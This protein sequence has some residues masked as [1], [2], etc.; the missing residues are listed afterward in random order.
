MTIKLKSKLFGPVYAL[1]DGTEITGYAF[2]DPS[3]ATPHP[4]IQ[5]PVDT[6]L[7]SDRKSVV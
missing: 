6:L 2:G 1:F 4:P 5:S 7:A 3:Q